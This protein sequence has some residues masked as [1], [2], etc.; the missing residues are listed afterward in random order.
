MYHCSVAGGGGEAGVGEGT[1][2]GEQAR[3]RG[4][5]AL[6]VAASRAAASMTLDGVEGCGAERGEGAGVEAHAQPQEGC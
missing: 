4:W 6:R 2:E 1:G 3:R 5:A